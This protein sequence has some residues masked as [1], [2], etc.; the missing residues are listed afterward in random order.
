MKNHDVRIRYALQPLSP[1][2]YNA[3]MCYGKSA[4]RFETSSLHEF[5]VLDRIP[6]SPD[7]L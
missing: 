6:L 3:G 4:I 5:S 1:V 7:L 2:L